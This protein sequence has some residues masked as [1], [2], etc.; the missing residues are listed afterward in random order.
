MK[1]Y[2]NFKL[3]PHRF[4]SLSHSLARALSLALSLSGYCLK[5]T[6]TVKDSR[7]CELTVVTFAECN[8]GRETRTRTNAIFNASN[9]NSQSVFPFLIL[10]CCGF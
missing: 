10:S 1:N 7:D 6:Q 3:P 9:S 2:L 8:S 5:T 4:L